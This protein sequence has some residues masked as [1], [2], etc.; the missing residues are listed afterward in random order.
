MCKLTYVFMWKA[1]ETRVVL[2]FI[3]TKTYVHL[4][5]IRALRALYTKYTKISMK[6]KVKIERQN[7]ATDHNRRHH[8]TNNSNL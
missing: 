8:F 3:S 4:T 5:N 7:K 6:F 2:M 1:K